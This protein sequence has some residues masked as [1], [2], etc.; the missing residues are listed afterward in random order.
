MSERYPGPR[1]E[2]EPKTP[3]N[4]ILDLMCGEQYGDAFGFDPETCAELRAG[5][6]DGTVSDEKVFETAYGYLT[7]AGA[8][9]VEE[10]LAPW[11]EQPGEEQQS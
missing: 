4:E 5:L 6:E 8:D 1:V 11:M 10:V 7:Q 2:G 3:G 9:N